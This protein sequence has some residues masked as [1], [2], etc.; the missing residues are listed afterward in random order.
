MLSSDL[1]DA[2]S[3]LLAG[4]TRPE[5]SLD[6]LVRLL[7]QLLP[8][9][10]AASAARWREGK[11]I[12]VAASGRAVAELLAGQLERGAGPQIEAVR[13]GYMWCPDT[14]AVGRWPGFRAATLRAGVRSLFTLVHADGDAKVTVSL[15]GAR[16]DC[17]D[18]DAAA[19]A[20]LLTASGVSIPAGRTGAGRGAGP[21]S[22]RS[23]Q[24]AGQARQEATALL[25]RAL[26]VTEQ[27]ARDILRATSRQCAA[28]IGDTARWIVAR[29]A[30]F[31][32]R[33]SD[34][35]RPA[36]AKRPA[37]RAGASRLGPA[38][39]PPQRATPTPAPASAAQRDTSSVRMAG[40]PQ[41]RRQVTLPAVVASH[42]T[43]TRTG[44]P[45]D[46]QLLSRAV[47]EANRL[48]GQLARCASSLAQIEARLADTLDQSAENL[49]ARAGDLAAKAS[50]AREYSR[51]VGQL[52][53][54][55]GQ[56]RTRAQQDV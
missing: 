10:A 33:I 25:A 17:L 22:G 35:A 43:A 30:S 37:A 50:A 29:H 14:G 4:A 2:A 9:C 7:P 54:A 31:L 41:S 44:R 13:S 16:P 53:Q 27:Q 26:G 8:G 47:D 49:P 39:V 36:A 45:P 28:D 18:P 34:A 15:Y 40:E 20:C 3:R 21:R 48:R 12:E 23:G 5:R 51:Q 55:Y 52:A 38:A 56:D 1:T 19:L 32:A 46:R 24:S 42:D 11:A 6:P